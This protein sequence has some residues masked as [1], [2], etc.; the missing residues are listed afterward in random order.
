MIQVVQRGNKKVLSVNGNP[1]F[2]LAGEVHN[3]D[4][5]SPAYMEKIWDLADSLGMNTL[6]LP[7]SWEMTEPE[8]G[9]FDFSVPEA[10]IRQARERKMHIVFLWF[11]SWKNAECMYAPAWVKQDLHR[12]P[13]AQVE[14]GKNK[15]ARQIFPSFPVKMQYTT[16]SALGTETTRADARAFAALMRFLKEIDEQEQT[17]LAVQVENE[18]GLLSAAR[19]V[20]DEADAAFASPVPE[21]FLAYMKAHTGT[22]VEDIRAA[23]ESAPDG[24]SWPEVFGVAADEIFQAYHVARFVETVASTGKAVY[25]LPMAVNCWLDKGGAPGTYP[26]G[27]PVSRVHEIWSFCAPS[28]DVFCPDIYVPQFKAVCDEF[29]RRGNPLFIPET[30]THSYCAA[31]LLYTVGHYHAMCYS[32]FGFDDFGKPF[33]ASQGF[34]FGMDVND[35]ALKTPQDLAEYQAV[36]SLLREMLPLLADAYGT[37]RLQALSAETD[38]AVPGPDHSPYTAK[39]PS[40]DFGDFRV[41]VSLSESGTSAVIG[42]CLCLQVGPHECYIAGKACGITLASLDQENPHLDLVLA[43]EGSFAAGQWIPGRRLNGDETARIHLDGPSLLHLKFF[44]YGD[45]CNG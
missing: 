38:P 28:I 18:T 12:F 33:T 41:S 11:G 8:E 36:G 22:M 35:P 2:M 23:V 14:K 10:L 16:L 37:P 7:V 43:E 45:P 34:L 19:E 6:L 42:A 40:M 20:S 27:G 44:V 26:T 29:T 31:R 5:S 17:V 21:D 32:P 24:G 25:N 30:A 9:R 39:L 4:S 1:Y 3:S 13:R 15:A